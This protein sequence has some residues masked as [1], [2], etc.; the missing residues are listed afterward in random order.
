MIDSISEKRRICFSFNLGDLVA[1][2]GEGDIT[3][4]NPYLEFFTPEALGE[5]KRIMFCYHRTARVTSTNTNTAEYN[6]ELEDIIRDGI[7]DIFDKES[8]SFV[9]EYMSQ[10]HLTHMSFRIEFDK[11][12]S[13]MN[14]F[15]L[16]NP[17]AYQ[18]LLESSVSTIPP[19][20]FIHER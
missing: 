10:I 7:L 13:Q 17:K 8:V 4:H 6:S 20:S 3:Y 11:Y 5:F 9:I 12:S 2:N 18:H 16:K 19:N 1:Y 15:K 14:A